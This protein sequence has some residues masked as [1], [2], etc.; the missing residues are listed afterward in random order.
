[1]SSVRPVSAMAGGRSTPVGAGG[2]AGR[3]SATA[4]WAPPA[5]AAAADGIE[6][7]EVIVAGICSRFEI[8]V[9]VE[10]ESSTTGWPSSRFAVRTFAG[11]RTRITSRLRTA[12]LP[13]SATVNG[14]LPSAPI[15]TRLPLVSRTLGLSVLA[16]TTGVALPGG[17]LVTMEAVPS[18]G[19]ETP[20]TTT[21]V[22]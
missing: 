22:S 4:A 14:V 19:T 7:E 13:V 10:T 12:K 8:P 6:P 21:A 20:P 5:G 1:G 9:D 11:I 2:G 15:R 3:D 18:R 16:P 17:V